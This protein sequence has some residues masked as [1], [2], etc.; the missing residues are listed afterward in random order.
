MAGWACLF[1]KSDFAIELGCG[2]QRSDCAI[3]EF[4][5]L[6][7]TAHCW[8]VLQ[9]SGLNRFCAAEGPKRQ[10]QSSDVL[11]VALSADPHGSYVPRLSFVER[12]AMLVPEKTE[13]FFRL[14]DSA[15]SFDSVCSQTQISR[16]SSTRFARSSPFR[17]NNVLLARP[18]SPL[19]IRRPIPHEGR[20]AI[21][22]DAGWDAVDAAAS[23]A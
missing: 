11:A 21:V 13:A 1:N 6:S 19:K 7:T 18:K 20:I 8:V 15:K 9:G 22:T 17:K 5:L 4:E 16:A 23:G 10:A 14:S 2:A 3:K 12:P